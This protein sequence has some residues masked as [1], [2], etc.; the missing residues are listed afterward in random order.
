MGEGVDMLGKIYLCKFGGPPT[1][2][3][4]I[5]WPNT[6]PPL[7]DYGL[8]GRQIRGGNR[9]VWCIRMGET[10]FFRLADGGGTIFLDHW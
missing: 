10:D 8:V 6:L 4:K 2:G 9:T 1:K 3:G 7:R 5:W